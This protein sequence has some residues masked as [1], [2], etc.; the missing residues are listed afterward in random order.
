MA[1]TEVDIVDAV[2]CCHASDSSLEIEGT[3]SLLAQLPPSP[4]CQ[5]L[6]LCEHRGIVSY[7]PADLT[8]TVRAGTMLAD[9]DCEL[10]RHG[11]EC[12]IEGPG[13]SVG[14]R[15]ASAL[16][17]L[18]RLGSGPVRDWLL[19]MRVV[20]ADGTIVRFG[21]PTVKNVTGY[22]LTR[23]VCGSW[24]TLAVFTEITLRLRPRP[25][26]RAWYVTDLP[27]RELLRVLRATSIV[28]RRERTHV[29]LEGH[30]ADCLQQVGR[31]GLIQSPPPRLPAGLRLA[32]PPAHINN[33]LARIDS[34]YAAEIGVGIIHADSRTN[35]LLALR[36]H[37]EALGGRLLVL[38]RDAGVPAFGGRGPSD[39]HDR[40][41]H[42]LDPR[43]LF[44]PW[45]FAA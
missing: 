37:C 28:R 39:F 40:V 10:E 17:G 7:D 41:K 3:G 15:V 36:R 35:N 33:T 8:V 9:L 25:A 12:P 38:K 23:L 5:R 30:P 34:D 45:R 44:A 43:G 1:V 19:G 29:L 2:C 32:V 18:R 11:Q 21:G 31:C 26:F 22:D 4:S 24:G 16:S 6:S 27:E 14:G 20:T 42:A 13:R